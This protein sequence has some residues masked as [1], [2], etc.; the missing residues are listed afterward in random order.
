MKILVIGSKGFIGSHLIHYFRSKYQHVF[1]CDVIFD[2]ND[3][4][5]AGLKKLIDSTLFFYFKLLICLFIT[6]KMIF[7]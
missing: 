2:E 5:E 1:G 4:K 3:P 7:A 6:N